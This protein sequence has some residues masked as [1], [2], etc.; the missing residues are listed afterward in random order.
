MKNN[1]TLTSDVII[2]DGPQETSF[3]PTNKDKLISIL[4]MIQT[5]MKKDAIYY[6]GK[7][8]NGK[9][10]AEYF[11]KIGAATAALAQIIENIIKE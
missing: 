5:D 9:N 3:P 8:F 11:G 7:E 1:M 6:E 4:K 10:V 2:S